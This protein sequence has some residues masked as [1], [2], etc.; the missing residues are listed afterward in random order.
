MKCV[1]VI[2]LLIT[3]LFDLSDGHGRLL[4]PPGRSSV[5]RDPRFK[6]DPSFQNARINYDDNGLNCGG[7]QV[8]CKQ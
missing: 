4:D 7:Y 3:C 1:V 6:T 2:V 8:S 5:W